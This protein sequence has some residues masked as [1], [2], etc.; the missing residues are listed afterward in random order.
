MEVGRLC[1]EGVNPLAAVVIRPSALPAGAAVYIN[2]SS[3]SYGYL[4]LHTGLVR[5]SRQCTGG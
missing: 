3:N 1:V 2:D 5:A 4:G